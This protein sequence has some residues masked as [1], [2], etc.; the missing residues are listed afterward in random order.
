MKYKVTNDLAS[1]QLALITIADVTATKHN[2]LVWE[3]IEK[4]AKDLRKKHTLETVRAIKAI[5]SVREMFKKEGMDST[6]YRPSSEAL[7]RRVL[8]GQSLYQVNSIVDVN[9]WCS[10][11]FLLPM[12]VY[13]IGNIIGN[14]LTFRHGSEGETYQGIGKQIQNAAEKIVMADEK[15]ICGEPVADS[16]RTMISLNTENMLMVIYAP[17]TMRPKELKMCTDTTAQRMTK[18]NG[19]VLRE[20][21]YI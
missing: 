20:V 14:A 17:R 10:L 9:N 18:Y 16:E 8:Q 2:Q 19:G 6:R 5:A 13:D 12:G 4:L 3:H 21:V 15:G 11:E 7:L 1:V